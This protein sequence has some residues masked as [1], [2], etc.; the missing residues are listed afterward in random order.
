MN[1][2]VNYNRNYINF[3]CLGLTNLH[4]EW[5]GLVYQSTRCVMELGSVQMALMKQIAR[6]NQI[7]VSSFYN[8]TTFLF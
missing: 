3:I 7:Q 8:N 6:Q 1:S 5:M 4:A 2:N